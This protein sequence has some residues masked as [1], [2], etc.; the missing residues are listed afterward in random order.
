LVEHIFSHLGYKPFNCPAAECTQ[1][2]V[3]KET[4]KK[5]LTKSHSIEFDEALH[6]FKCSFQDI[7]KAGLKETVSSTTIDSNCDGMEQ[8]TNNLILV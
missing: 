8:T 1:G 3:K 5:H 6:G 4:F 7:L 2:F